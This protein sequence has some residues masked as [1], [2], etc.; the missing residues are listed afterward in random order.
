MIK[1]LLSCVLA[2]SLMCASLPAF[3]ADLPDGDAAMSETE[4]SDIDSEDL[5]ES[6]DE[7]QVPDDSDGAVETAQNAYETVDAIASETGQDDIVTYEAEVVDDADDIAD[8][9][10]VE[11][12]ALLN[13]VVVDKPYVE[14]G[15]TQN[16]VVSIGDEDTQIESAVLTYHRQSD[17][18]TY[19]VE[20]T[21]INGG[22][23][24]FQ[25]E[26]PEG[27]AADVYWLDAV[28]YVIGGVVT[29]V[30]FDEIGID[31]GYGVAMEV[32]TNPDGYLVDE[33][34]DYETEEGIVAYD[35]DG[36]QISENSIGDAIAAEQAGIPN[37]MAAS[38]SGTVVVVLDPG[39]D[40][41]HAGARSASGLCEETLN[42]K[43]AKYCKEEL[44]QYNGVKVYMTRTTESC[45]FPG[46]SNSDD[47]AGRVDYAESV[48]A[49]VYVSL[50]CN[51][52]DSS[53]P[54]GSQ[55]YCPNKNYNASISEEGFA[56]ANV[57][58][59]QLNALGLSSRGIYSVDSQSGT[60][61]PDGS[62]ADY[63][64]VIR[65]SK[66]A[67]F[68]GIIVEHA[69]LSNTSDVN[70]YL[71]SDA[72]LKNLGVADATGIANYFGLKKG[73]TDIVKDSSTGKWVYTVDG[74]PDY[75]Y[76]GVAHNSNGWWYVKDGVVDFSYNGFSSN[77]NG[78]W[79]CEGGQVKFNKNSVIQDT[80]GAIGTK[81]AWWYV[82]G[83]KV[84]TS[85]TGVTN[86]SNSNGWWYVV[87]GK[88]DFSANTVAKNNNG[89]WYVEGGKVIFSY[90]GFG[91]N[92]NGKWY[93]ENGKVN[94]NKNSVIE[95]KTG[96]IGTKGTWWYVVGSEVQTNFTGLADY[97]N[98]NGWWYIEKGKVTFNKNTVA[99]N[100]NGW[101][102]VKNSKVD[103]NFTG[104]ADFS[105]ENGWWY[106][107]KGK[108]TFKKDT[109]AK[110]K[111]GWWYIKDS[112]VDF[113]FTGLADFPN[114][115][116]WWYVNDG[117][118]TFDDN[119]VAHNK[120]GWY[121]VKGSKVDFNFT[122]IAQ[123]AN[124]WWY[125]NN[126]KVDFSFTGTVTA[127]GTR[128]SVTNGKV[129]K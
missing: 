82:V 62:L 61:Y 20:A 35:A 16:I 122:G 53:E 96:A 13:F 40:S 127:S 111:N 48:G 37:T 93:C 67:G 52:N 4:I 38:S 74:V 17:G 23:L 14:P 19:E 6:I 68:P 107:E 121:Y 36:N 31:A 28:S 9:E 90:N 64:A 115:N 5:S 11:E 123:N 129:A 43:I 12:T 49:T 101:F 81:G 71:S 112:K 30:V 18:N 86:Y 57:I 70:N 7:E 54:T 2:A 63:Y 105:N 104:L 45:P 1:K 114:E 51:S 33:E 84:Q 50:H 95:D 76:T 32:E 88:V 10:S 117:K 124:G 85:Y 87:N 56:L 8:T 106:I 120:N 25:I 59:E 91:S 39:H 65:R 42:L 55:V 60:K 72:S 100:K 83:S 15:E 98:S 118:V 92:S 109:V 97:S 125:I 41:T 75:T 73:T 44:E 66:L 80:T 79:Y 113:S 69:F 116:G 47:L 108:V 22:G 27:S 103:F 58:M 26:Y 24:L 99:K 102:Y 46:S 77:S 126:G 29:E 110:N 34:T 78:L 94:F 3:A 21:K 89:W 128:Y 119:T